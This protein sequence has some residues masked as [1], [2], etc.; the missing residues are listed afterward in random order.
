MISIIIPTYNE[1]STVEATVRQ[2]ADLGLPHEVI[3][4]DG[5]SADRTAKLARQCADKVIVLGEDEPRGVSRQRNKGASEATGEFIVF[6]DSDTVVPGPDRF[7]AKALAAFEKDP[8]L[9]AVSARIEVTPDVRTVSDW[10]VFG[11]MNLDFFLMNKMLHVGIA[12][13][14]FQMV[15]TKAFRATGGFNPNLNTAED[16]DLFGRLAKIGRTRIL[17]ELAVFHS[18]RRVHQLGAWRTL[19]RWMKNALTMWIF[20]RPSKEKWETIR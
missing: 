5:R 4:V 16:V 15:R 18:G 14:K 6:L 13:G 20:K 1:E 17:W 3:V 10:L 19:G 11:L 9:V 12:S 7:F 8:R 2:F